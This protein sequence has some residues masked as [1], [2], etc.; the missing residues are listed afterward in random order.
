MLQAIS[1]IFLVCHVSQVSCHPVLFP[2]FVSSVCILLFLSKLLFTGPEGKAFIPPPSCPH[3]NLN[4][5]CVF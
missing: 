5:S 4:Q 1:V 2:L 3:L